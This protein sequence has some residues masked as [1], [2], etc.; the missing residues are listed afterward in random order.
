MLVDPGQ[1]A[2]MDVSD[3]NVSF[4]PAAHT[5]AA[6]QRP[7]CPRVVGSGGGGHDI[8][9]GPLGPCLSL[10]LVPTGVPSS[11]PKPLLCTCL[12]YTRSSP[13]AVSFLFVPRVCLPGVWS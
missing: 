7:G 3:L 12:T 10:P 4:T 6:P 1:T 9:S 11:G 2:R 5:R 8:S 13:G